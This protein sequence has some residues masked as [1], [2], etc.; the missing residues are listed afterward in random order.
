MTGC[1]HEHVHLEWETLFLEDAQCYVGEL[2]ITCTDCG[3][4]FGFK[5]LPCGATVSDGAFVDPSGTVLRVGLRSPSEQAL[6][7]PM[8]GLEG[9]P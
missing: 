5:G 3:L 8:A 6:A 9:A 7:G 2:K 4:P 1:D